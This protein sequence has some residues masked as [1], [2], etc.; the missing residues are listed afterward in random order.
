MNPWQQVLFVALRALYL[1]IVGVACIFQPSIGVQ[2]V[3]SYGGAGTNR[4]H[5]KAAYACF[6]QI[7][8]APQTNSASPPTVFLGPHDNQC[9][10]VRQTASEAR[11]LTSPI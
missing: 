11:V 7:G 4:L 1:P 6:G 10:I 8:N 2:S 9:L 3:R 5:N